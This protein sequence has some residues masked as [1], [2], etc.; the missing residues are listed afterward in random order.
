MVV[1]QFQERVHWTVRATSPSTTTFNSVGAKGTT[2]LAN[3]SCIQERTIRGEE[4][5]RQPDPI[6]D[7]K[8]NRGESD[9]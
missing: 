2:A 6:A 9:L 5:T 8:F 3:H 1:K 4:H 7:G